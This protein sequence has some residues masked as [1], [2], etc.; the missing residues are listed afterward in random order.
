MSDCMDSVPAIPPRAATGIAGLDRVLGGGLPRNRT[1]LVEGASGTGKTTLALAFALEGVR[2][3][4][5]VL[6]VSLSESE[7]E[8]L[9]VIA[10]HGWSA[11]GLDILELNEG[12][13]DEPALSNQ[14]TLFYPSEVELGENTGRVL[15]AVERVTPSR[16]VL[17]TVS[18][19]RLLADEPLRYRRQLQ[20]LRRFFTRRGCTVLLVDEIEA[21]RSAFQPRSLVHGIIRL[22]AIA[23]EYGPER[24]RLAIKK[25]R[26]VDFLT[27]FHDCGLG[28]GGLCVYP[29][30]SAP[31]TQLGPFEG[32]VRSG[33]E[34]LDALLGGGLERGGS[35]LLTGSSGTGKSTL[36]LAYAVAA[37]QRGEHTIMLSFDEDLQSIRLRAEGLGLDLQ[38]HADS[39]R[40]RLQKVNPTQITPGEF[41]HAVVEQVRAEGTRLVVIDSLSGYLYAMPDEP[42]LSLHLHELLGALRAEGVTTLMT[43]V[44]H[45]L[46]GSEV[47][48]PADVS[49]LADTII[50]LRYFEATGEVR[51][52]VSVLKK[53]SGGHE[54]TIRELRIDG[55]GV[56]VGAPLRD[57]QGVLTGTP[58]Y[59]GDG[60]PFLGPKP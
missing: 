54:S 36:C 15:E 14:Y 51:K 8:L 47:Q 52:A 56:R 35:A 13:E 16:V 32:R 42:F 31:H 2:G 33:I 59:V 57:F 10:S 55:T 30:L 38:Q 4:E 44:Q 50:L 6:F 11:A 1:Y 17:D 53:R 24:R 9:E 25:L 22:E 26:G 41:A 48:S 3:G 18:G 29:R 60:R 58:Q 12:E 43:L 40:I 45:G 23:H 5:R 34:E 37:A 19:L 39:D 7:D 21:A 46:L 28:V 20:G 27:G 49:Y